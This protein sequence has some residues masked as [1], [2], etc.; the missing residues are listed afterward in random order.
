MGGAAKG[1]LGG[2]A[3][4]AAGAHIE[5]DRVLAI[6]MHTADISHPFRQLDAHVNFSIRIRDEFFA[7]GDLERKRNMDVSPMFDRHCYGG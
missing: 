6:L 7:Q 2:G 5:R 3:G 4:G 1:G